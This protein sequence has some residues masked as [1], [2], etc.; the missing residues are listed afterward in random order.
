MTV[1]SEVLATSLQ[2]VVLHGQA[3]PA[4]YFSATGD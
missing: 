2:A 3:Q 4:L 1:P